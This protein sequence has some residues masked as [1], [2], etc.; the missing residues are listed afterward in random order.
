MYGVM[1][2]A[3]EF[4]EIRA[5][6]DLESKSWETLRNHPSFYI[7]AHRG[8]ALSPDYVVPLASQK[9]CVYYEPNVAN[10]KE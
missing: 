1:G 4:K 10:L 6:V 5:P 7:F 3:G 9:S 8:R 2:T